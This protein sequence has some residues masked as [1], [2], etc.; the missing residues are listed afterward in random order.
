LF[1]HIVWL[2]IKFKEWL[3]ITTYLLIVIRCGVWNLFMLLY[4]ELLTINYYIFIIPLMKNILKNNKKMVNSYPLKQLL[5]SWNKVYLNSMD[6]EWLLRIS[7]NKWKYQRENPQKWS[8]LI[9]LILILK[10]LNIKINLE[11]YITDHITITLSIGKTVKRRIISLY[12]IMIKKMK[13]PIQKMLLWT[14]LN[15]LLPRCKNI[16]KNSQ[17]L[18]N[19]RTINW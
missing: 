11:L 14:H 2:F 10:H 16:K 12:R 15:S 5:I 1:L 19:Q 17:S 8:R 7:V 3:L 4:L 18:K 6:L 13:K 9:K